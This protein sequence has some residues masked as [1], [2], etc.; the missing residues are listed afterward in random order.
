MCLMW[1]WKPMQSAKD[2]KLKLY[3]LWFI[4]IDLKSI[5]IHASSLDLW[6][7]DLDLDSASMVVGWMHRSYVI[8]YVYKLGTKVHMVIMFALD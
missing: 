6:A 2:I 8:S 4:L 7:I 5:K 1:T 3:E